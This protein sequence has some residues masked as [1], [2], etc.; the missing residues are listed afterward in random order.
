LNEF[1]LPQDNPYAPYWLVGD[2]KV[3]NQIEAN[4]LAFVE[5]GPSYRLVFLEKEYD[6]LDWVTEPN[7]EWEKLCIQRAIQLRQKYKKL[8]LCFSAGRDSG[9]VWRIFEK[10]GIPIDELVFKRFMMSTIDPASIIV[11]TIHM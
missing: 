11:M 5:G 9:H 4:K 2:K 7:E 6:T 3:Y 8:K 1:I 10:A